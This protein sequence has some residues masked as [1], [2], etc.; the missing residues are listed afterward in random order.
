RVLAGSP[1]F[2]T[3]AVLSLA[4]GIGAN[5]AIFSFADALLL[6]PLPVARPG[7]VLTVGSATNFEALGASSLVASYRD[8]IDIRDRNKSFDG[9]A[10]YRDVTAGFAA[11]PKA[12]PKLKLGMLVSGN[13]FTL[14]GVQPT[15]GRT[16]GP[17]ED[18]VPD[19]D[20]VVVLGRA[21][22][23]QE[24][25]SEPGVLGRRVRIN[26][27]EFTVIGVTP[28]EFN[29]LNQ[30]VRSDF[31]VPLMMS[32]RLVSDPKGSSLENRDARNLKLKGRLRAGVSQ[33]AAQAELTTIA[34]DL[35]R[36]YPETNKNRRLF[37]RKELQA[38]I[39]QSPPDAMLIAMLSTLALAVL[40]VA[41][42]NVAGL[43]ASRA[44]ARAREMALRLAIGAGRGH[45]IRQLVTE[46]LLIA[47]LGGVLGLGVGYAGMTLFRQIELPTDLP[48]AISF[49][50][51]RRALLF[52]LAVSFASAVLF[53][54]VPAIQATR[55]DL[56][57]VMK[58]SDSVAPGRRRRWG[59][60][61]LVGGQV[62]VSVVLLVVAL[63]MYRGFGKEVA[64]GPGYRTDHLLMMSFDTGLL[65]YTETQSKL[66]FDQ[67]AER[68]RAVPGVKTVAMTTS[69][70]MANDTIGFERVVPEGF[71]FAP[72]KDNATVLAARVDEQYFD[73]LG[74]TL[75]RG[76]NF[77]ADD[78]FDRPRVAIVNQ[79]FA[80]HYWPN[81]DPI[82]KRFQTLGD[83]KE[84]VQV[85]GL[86][87]TSKYIFI[88]EAPVEFV[89]FPHRQKKLREMTLIAQS[90]GDAGALAAPLREMV[91]GL[92]PNMPIYNVRTMEQFYQMRAISIFRV[93]VS[94][95]AGMG[96]MGLGLAIVGLYGLVS[97]AA[98]RRT[99]EIGIRMAIGADRGAVSRMVLRQGAVLAV[100]GLVIGLAGSVGAGELLRAAF[101]GDDQRDGGALLIV[102]PI[103][104]SVTLL[105][106]YLPA[107]RASR[108][109]PVQAL[110][111]D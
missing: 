36:A 27:A 29:G 68:A 1:G 52:S 46:S 51:D 69:V 58:A 78:S 21:M 96:A 24:F 65:R 33:A 84:W 100:V 66:F 101:P 102:I 13:L 31:F 87:K 88:A 12:T 18:E 80:Q 54:L 49:Q 43:L 86:A 59:R 64:N 73:T 6:R 71:Q 77:S 63:F 37:V 110:R 104:L 109:N 2:T 97:Y 98:A 94:T 32:Q 45:L 9:L 61:V 17:E 106:A 44:P 89:Y 107:R 99:R 30:Y 111:H 93:L 90:Q 10:A 108:L 74:L 25:R 82:G 3:I 76:R 67:V 19:R 105:A 83:E 95:V 55:T 4:I 14:M 60:S 39:D 103:V 53:G 81:Q 15:I 41:C 56:T 79:P 48:I 62:A 35:E 11:D 85:V 22:W 23:E 57:A 34:A 28:P 91:R 5:C 16:F 7:E 42:A 50:L 47:I 70:P 75:L 40:F 92:D 20:A 8:Y 72:G 26:G 38:R